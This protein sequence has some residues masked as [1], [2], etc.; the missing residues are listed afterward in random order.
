MGG[1][2]LL[3]KMAENA[4]AMCSAGLLEPTAAVAM[5]STNQSLDECGTRPICEK[6]TS[7]CQA[8]TA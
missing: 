8:M 7:C 6:R 1:E 5:A 3:K 2:E 4:N